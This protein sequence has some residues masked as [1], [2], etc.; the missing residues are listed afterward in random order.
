MYSSSLRLRYSAPDC[1]AGP[2]HHSTVLEYSIDNL[3]EI[4]FGIISSLGCYKKPAGFIGNVTFCGCSGCYAQNVT[5]EV[6]PCTNLK[7]IGYSDM[8]YFNLSGPVQCV[9][10]E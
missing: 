6:S 8:T 5:T 3:T 2:G 1:T 9:G 10:F 4:D 7:D